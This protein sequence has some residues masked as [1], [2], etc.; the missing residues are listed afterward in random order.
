M[1]YNLILL[2]V[3][4]IAAQAQQNDQTPNL[5]WSA[6]FMEFLPVIK[7]DLSPSPIFDTN[8]RAS[9]QQQITAAQ[10]EAYDAEKK[11]ERL[12]QVADKAKLIAAQK[13]AEVDALK[14]ANL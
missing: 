10:Q 1:K 14:K 6:L 5:E 7:Q 2:G 12:Q 9:I 11:Y 3:F 13:S 8:S 4:T